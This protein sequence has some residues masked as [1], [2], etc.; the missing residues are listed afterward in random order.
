M[1]K[2]KSFEVDNL[3]I[4]VI[5]YA[6]VEWLVRRGIFAAFREN[7]DRVPTARKTFRDCLRDHIRYVYRSPSLGPESLISSAF[8][9]T[10][11]PEGYEFWIKHSDAWVRF[12]NNL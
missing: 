11:A 7:Y 10:E 5:E 4:D 2:G 8:L 1:K 12:Y 6:F 9:F 3:A